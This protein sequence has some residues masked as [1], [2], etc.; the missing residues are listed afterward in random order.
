MEDAHAVLAEYLCGVIILRVKRAAHFARPV[1][2]HARRTQAEAG[3]GDV[4]LMAEAP[5]TALC[6]VRPDKSDVARTKLCL[7]ERSHRAARDKARHDKA[8]R[9]ERG[10]YVQHV[11]L[12]ARRLQKEAV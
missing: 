4:E 1:V 9:T 2:P 11:R 7:D 5:R 6:H 12:G 3:V 10:R 8:F